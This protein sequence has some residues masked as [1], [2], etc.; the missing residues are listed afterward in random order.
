MNPD[1]L[2]LL[3]AALTQLPIFAILVF[4]YRY[5]R[6]ILDAELNAHAIEGNRRDEVIQRFMSTATAMLPDLARSVVG[7]LAKPSKADEIEVDENGEAEP[8]RW[9]VSPMNPA[10][11]W[12]FHVAR[13]DGR[14]LGER[15]ASATRT[16]SMLEQARIV[17]A[18][19][20]DE[21]D[22]AQFGMLS[23]DD[24]VDLLWYAI[25]CQIP[26]GASEPADLDRVQSAQNTLRGLGWC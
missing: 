8:V 26:E 20:R 10:D 3:H 18:V 19:I 14:S 24:R 11:R 25:G 6:Q 12:L 4:L 22:V 13:E 15:E 23:I 21:I 1:T 7:L 5:K 9:V 16:L 2:S 17:Q